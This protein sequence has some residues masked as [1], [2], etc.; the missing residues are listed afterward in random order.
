[1]ARSTNTMAAILSYHGGPHKEKFRK[2]SRR[3]EERSHIEDSMYEYE[4]ER[5]KVEESK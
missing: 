4:E 2:K 5:Y 3:E 1:M